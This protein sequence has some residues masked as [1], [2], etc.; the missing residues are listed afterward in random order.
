MLAWS[1][2]HFDNVQKNI[3]Q[4]KDRLWRAEEILARSGNSEE[5]AQLK[6]KLNV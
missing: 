3:K 5:V 2:D 6:K 1:R 4:L